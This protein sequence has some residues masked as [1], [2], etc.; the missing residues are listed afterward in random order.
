MATSAPTNNDGWT[1]PPGSVGNLTIPQQHTLEKFRKE[2][3]ESGKFDEKRH[4]DA[5]LL[6]FLRARKFDQAASMTML[7]N[8]E[9]WRKT[10]AGCGVDELARTFDFKERSQVDKFYPQY[11]HKMDKEGRPLYIERL[12]KINTTEM[13]KITTQDRLLQNLVC[14]YERFQQ[15]RLPACSKAIGHPVETSCTILDLAGVGVKQFWDVKNYVSEASKIGQDRYPETMGRFYMINAPWGFSTVWNI[16]KGWLD[17]VTQAKIKILGSSYQ[18]DLL[19]NIDADALPSDLGGT[20]KCEGGCS[21]SDAGPWNVKE[22]KEAEGEGE[23]EQVIKT[24][25]AA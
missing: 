14:E 19:E 22:K 18:K 21:L 5:N 11:Y 9:E 17:P 16:I 20:C 7:M 12:G 1:P 3:Q 2:L 10:F 23:A 6:R 25:T 4:D 24:G 15:E 8:Y 13:Y